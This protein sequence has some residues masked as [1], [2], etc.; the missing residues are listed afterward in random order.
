MKI[1]G[2]FLTSPISDEDKI[3]TKETFP[4][5]LREMGEA[6]REFAL[7]NVLPISDEIDNLDYD[8]LKKLLREMG[9]MG[10]TAV[11]IPE[12]YGGLEL[13]LVTSMIMMEEH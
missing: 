3:L 10:F 6:M 4:D 9:E 8:L 13:D 5:E 7:N 12:K 11:D 2:S 1:G